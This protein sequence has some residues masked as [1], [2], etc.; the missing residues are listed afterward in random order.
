MKRNTLHVQDF[1]G[2]LHRF[3]PPDLAQEWDNVG[4]QVGEPDGAVQRIMVALDP[5]MENLHS[6]HT[7]N[8]QLL[9]THHPLIFK[10][11]K[12]ISTSDSTGRIIAY[13]LRHNIHIVCAHTN[14]DSGANGLNDWL[15]ATLHL[16]EPQIL[17]PSEQDRFFKLVVYVPPSHR[18]ELLQALFRGG[19][20]H[21]G[22][23]DHCAFSVEGRGQ[24]RPGADANPFLGTPG[25]EE[26]EEEVRIETI[27]PRR[28]LNK[29]LTQMRRAHPYEEVAY[30]LFELHN[31]TQTTGLG[32][33]GKLPEATTLG[34]FAH[35]CKEQLKCANLRIVGQSD[36]PVHRIAVCSGSGSSA[37]YAAKFS[38]ADVLVTG[39]LK[40]H[41]AQSAAE[42]GICVIDAGHF[43][44]EIIATAGLQSI[45]T[46]ALHLHGYAA[47]IIIAPAEKDPFTFI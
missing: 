45:L 10:P 43:A 6:A 15:A 28:C 26:Q 42:L 17:Q 30:D 38:G 5:S 24:F 19:A 1:I 36:A 46:P 16:T 29:V 7:N 14:L 18:E 47:E 35:T 44:T 3:Y 12:R 13:A 37:L 9:L 39:D 11:L 41:E 40:Y 20:G 21:I 34:A 27:V 22:R 2:L 32:R 4:L 25:Q 33:I 8:C 31:Q 23:Y